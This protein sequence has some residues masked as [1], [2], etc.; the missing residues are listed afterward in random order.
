MIFVV[1][2]FSDRGVG[3]L[4]E[5]VGSLHLSQEASEESRDGGIDKP[6]LLFGLNHGRP[7][8]SGRNGEFD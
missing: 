1:F 8:K 6:V 7:L 2:L 3:N 4:D 5:D